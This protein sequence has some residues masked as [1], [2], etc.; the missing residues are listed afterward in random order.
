[1]VLQD[2]NQTADGQ[3]EQNQEDG[4]IKEANEVL[5]FEEKDREILNDTRIKKKTEIGHFSETSDG[6]N[7]ATSSKIRKVNEVEDY[8]DAQSAL[9]NISNAYNKSHKDRR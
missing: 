7:E 1:M 4:R 8:Q 5:Y 9:K 2:L 6:R 3:K